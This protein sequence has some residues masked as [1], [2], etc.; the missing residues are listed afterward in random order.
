MPLHQDHAGVGQRRTGSQRSK[1]LTWGGRVSRAE[2]F[3]RLVDDLPIVSRVGQ[4]DEDLVGTAIALAL[5]QPTHQ[6]LDIADA[7]YA[8][9]AHQQ[10]IDSEHEIPRSPVADVW[11]RHLA[12][13]RKPRSN[14]FQQPRDDRLVSLVTQTI[15]ERVQARGEL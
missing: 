7:R 15:A 10:V 6:S 11:K 1:K 3:A 8:F 13:M 4:H 5:A 9:D 2:S 14:V 12:R